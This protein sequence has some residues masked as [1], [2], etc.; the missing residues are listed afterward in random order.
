MKSVPDVVV[1]ILNILFCASFLSFFFGGNAWNI[2]IIHISSKSVVIIAIIASWICL[3]T[4][5]GFIWLFLFVIAVPRMATG[6]S[7]MGWWGVVYIISA[8]MGFCLQTDTI[9]N[10]LPQLKRE[11]FI[12][13]T[14]VT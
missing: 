12:E 10:V 11:F 6:N 3:P 2:P 14:D 8:F 7:A 13:H 1:T 4:I 5:A 9:G